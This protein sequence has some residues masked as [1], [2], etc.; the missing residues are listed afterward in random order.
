MIDMT[1]GSPLKLITKFMLPLLLGNV[2][3]QLYNVV[4]SIV[5]GN[6]VGPEAL[7]AVSNS[8]IVMF[9]LMSLFGGIGMGATILIAQFLGAKQNE[10]IKRTV[11][12]MYITLFVGGLALSLFGFFMA[13]TLLKLLNTPEG[14]ITEMSTIY[15][16]TITVGLILNFGY[17]VNNGILQG[18]GD[19]KS[20]LLFLG[21]ATVINIVLDLLFVAFFGLGVFG[22]AL[23]TIIAQGFSFIFGIFYI[24]KKITVFKVRLKG[25]KFSPDILRKSLKIGF[26]AAIQNMLVSLG[27]LLLQRLINSYGSTFMAGFSAGAKIDA[28]VFMPI[29]SFGSAMTTFVGQNIGAK[30][31]D[32]VKIGVRTTLALA[33]GLSLLLSAACILCGK[34]LL[35]AFVDDAAVIAVG[36]EYIFRVMIGF[37][38]LAILFVLSAVIRGAG[39]TTVPLVTTIISML[40][41]RISSAYF[42]A[43]HFGQNN[44]FWCFATDWL[45]SAVILGVY[46]LSGHWKKKCMQFINDKAPLTE[47]TEA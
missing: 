26:P 5:V 25:M 39:Q 44:I 40:G 31:L 3:Q 47:G 17:S 22:V 35:H 43:E 27:V 14:S 9:L 29:M 20:S 28:F 32:R 23:A 10:D 11:D 15:L 4:D 24:N 2:L 33:L 18:I 45:V 42:Y 37:P 21:I 7:A 12:T 38:F 34:F 41:A 30:R 16:R 8:F 13:P 36:Q 1:K 46:Y 19:G 6:F